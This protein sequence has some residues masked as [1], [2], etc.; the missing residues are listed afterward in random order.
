MQA[1][2]LQTKNDLRSHEQTLGDYQPP[3]K[4]DP[5]QAHARQRSEAIAPG[6][7]GDRKASGR[8]HRVHGLQVVANV[9]VDPVKSEFSANSSSR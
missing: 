5:D 2:T 3:P 7:D 6:N 9:Y 8:H 4:L 1:A